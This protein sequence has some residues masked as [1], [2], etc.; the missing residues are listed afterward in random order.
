MKII[1]ALMADTDFDV[2]IDELPLW[3]EWVEIQTHNITLVDGA[4]CV[5]L[6]DGQK[7]ALS[8]LT[9]AG[10]D[11]K[12]A[13]YIVRLMEKGEKEMRKAMYYESLL[14]EMDP[15]QQRTVY[16]IAVL[17]KDILEL[18]DFDPPAG[19]VSPSYDR[20]FGSTA[21][22]CYC[23]DGQWHMMPSTKEMMHLLVKINSRLE[24]QPQVLF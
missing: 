4:S 9:N 14:E 17:C 3:R 13:L 5:Y 23:Q 21:R 19:A 20:V 2:Y 24:Q 15:L 22:H 8:Y 10:I 18:S 11:E 1:S 7:H 12:T 6:Y 16:N